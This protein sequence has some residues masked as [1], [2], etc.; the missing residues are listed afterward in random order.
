MQSEVRDGEARRDLEHLAD[1]DPDKY[2]D[3]SDRRPLVSHQTE[4]QRRDRHAEPNLRFDEPDAE[5]G[6]REAES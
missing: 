6:E 1:P 3:E 5:P 2:R 4:H